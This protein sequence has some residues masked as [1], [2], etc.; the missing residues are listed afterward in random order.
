[1]TANIILLWNAA[2]D[3]A[4]AINKFG[5]FNIVAIFADNIV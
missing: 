3:N 1:M 4:R 2:I 5:Y